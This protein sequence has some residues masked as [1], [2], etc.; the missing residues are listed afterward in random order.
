MNR[1]ENL[2]ESSNLFNDDE[3]LISL[4]NEVISN[5]VI[6]SFMSYED[7]TINPNE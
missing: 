7:T 6:S 5:S 3:E 2:N 1:A 4:D